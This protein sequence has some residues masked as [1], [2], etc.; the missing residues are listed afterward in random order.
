[1]MK[2]I[3]NFVG[4]RWLLLFL[5]LKEIQ[6]DTQYQYAYH[7]HCSAST[8]T[9]TAVANFV[10]TEMEVSDQM[11]DNV[12]ILSRHLCSL[13]LWDE[14]TKYVQSTNYPI[15]FNTFSFAWLALT[16]VSKL[17]HNRQLSKHSTYTL[18]MMKTSRKPSRHT[19]V[20]QTYERF[21]VAGR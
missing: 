5:L 1:M 17:K 19:G 3:S 4:V 6:F 20:R 10:R 11:K 21:G 15:S 16:V 2:L 13:F 7:I 18:S 8:S 12:W 14:K 9:T